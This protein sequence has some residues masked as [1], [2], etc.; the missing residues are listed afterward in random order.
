MAA[1]EKDRPIII[2][3]KVKKVGGGHHGGSWKVA[4]A[5]FVTAMMAFFMVMWLVNLDQST[6]TLIGGY[7]SNPTA[8]RTG[9]T[10]SMA[11][12]PVGTPSRAADAVPMQ[13]AMRE[14]ERQR[15][16]RAA[17]SLRQRIE[18][19]RPELGLRTRIEITVTEEGLRIELIEDGAGETFFPLGSSA[20]SETGRTAL[21]LISLELA[22]LTA[23]VV[24]EGHTDAVQYAR[25]AA[26]TNWELSADRANAA[27][28]VLESQGV[29]RS[30]V[31]GVRGLADRYLREPDNP[32]AASNR[33]I[34]ILLPF[35]DVRDEMDRLRES[36]AGA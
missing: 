14:A 31:V 22:E 6:R 12:I 8:F 17:E 30:R 27:R 33:R 5:D 21:K 28:R 7:F 10:T 4:Y 15:F 2:I 29:V 9:G 35:T 20:M 23:A 34:S 13:L 18:E 19:N 11:P 1:P 25:S 36:G 26:Y 16:E 24:I 32:A 3:K